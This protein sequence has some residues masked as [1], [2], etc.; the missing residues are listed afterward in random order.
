MTLTIEL[1]PEVESSLMAQAEARGLPLAQYVEYLLREQVPLHADAAV[2]PTERAAAWRES[3][4]GLPNTPPLS[5][6]A[7]SR[8][9]IYDD[10]I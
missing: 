2:S 5:D 6:D 8:T 9:S 7:I 3:V 4:K 10:R 1:P